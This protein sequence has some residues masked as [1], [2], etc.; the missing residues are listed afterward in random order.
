MLA[1]LFPGQ[2]SQSV[3]M[4]RELFEKFPDITAKAD[5]IL[6]YSI[7]SLC[8]GEMPAQLN[9]TQYTQPALFTVNSLIYFNK[10][11][12]NGR[13][14]SFVAGHSL[15]EYNALLAADV[16]DFESGLKMVQKRGEL[17]GKMTGGGMA[18]IIGL[19]AD[20][21][22]DILT[23]H[24]LTNVTIANYNSHSQI[25]ITGNKEDI[26]QAQALCEQ[27]NAA[28]VIPLV[29]SGA[30]HSQLMRAAQE[31]FELF[32]NDFKFA[33]PTIPVIANTTARPYLDKAIHKT[34]TEQITS[35]V[36]WTESIDYLLAQGVVDFEEIGPGKVL[37]G[38]VRRIKTGQ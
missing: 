21:I 35:S 28:M 8:L 6:G 31:Q 18:A 5:A 17:M 11:Q 2:G 15:G 13:K 23:Q 19:H 26:N 20:A 10:L 36:R 24:N 37:T 27:Y 30:F 33:T 34:I 29:V 7:Q 4:G 3:G 38:L 9:Q 16:F 25:V 32:I 14:P 22:R 12:D 1:Y